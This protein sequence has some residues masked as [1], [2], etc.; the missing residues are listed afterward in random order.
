MRFLSVKYSMPE[1]L[2]LRWLNDYG[3]EVTEKMLADF[4]EDKPLTVRCRT[5]LNSVEKT[6]ESL[7]AQGVT[8]EPAP[9]LPYAKRISGYNH[10]LALDAFIQGKI[11][12]QDVSSM[13]VAE[14]ADP[15][16]WMRRVLGDPAV[17]PAA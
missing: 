17:G 6:C 16:A 12:V 8:V 4:L 9:Y 2:V 15:K 10:I 3:E 13:L 7:R 1:P 11:Q 14:I 5:Y